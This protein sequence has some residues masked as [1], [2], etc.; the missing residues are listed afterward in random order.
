M[1][2]APWRHPR[3]ITGAREGRDRGTRGARRQGTEAAGG[4]GGHLEL[5]GM[6]ALGEACC[7]IL[8]A[9]D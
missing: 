5:P 1:A 4:H 8:A 2:E 7:E 3:G 9:P 6:V